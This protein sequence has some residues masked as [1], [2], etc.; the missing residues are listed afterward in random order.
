MAELAAGYCV[1]VHAFLL[2]LPLTFGEEKKFNCWQRQAYFGGL[3]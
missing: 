1:L 3:T 2:L